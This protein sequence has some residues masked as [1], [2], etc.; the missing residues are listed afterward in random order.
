MRR[1]EILAAALELFS[2]H[3]YTA[4]ST[5]R[6]A[7]AAGVTEGLVFHYF[8]TKFALLLELATR[9]HTF[10]GRILVRLD[11]LAG[12]PARQVLREFADGF[13]RVTRDEARFVGMMQAESMLNEELRTTFAG[14]TAVV[15]ERI[16]GYLATRVKTGELREDVPL[17]DAVL[18]F[19]GGFA[20]F[21]AQ[22]RHLDEA[23]WA[24]RAEAFA[25]AWAEIC[26]R[27]LARTELLSDHSTKTRT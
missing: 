7:A 24:V 17:A 5:K 10:A 22:H 9:R 16:A 26:W 6:I 15:V 2:E 1:E 27:G 21:F 12:E 4:T 18:G 23:A 11:A 13:A 14:T 8:P 19:F 25:N 3:G 20:F